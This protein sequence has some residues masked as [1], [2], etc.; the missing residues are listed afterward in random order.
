MVEDVLN[1]AE[2]PIANA[3]GNAIEAIGSCG[4]ELGRTNGVAAIEALDPHVF[5]VMQAEAARAHRA[6][7]ESGALDATL[8]K[9]LRKGLEID[10]ATL[11]AS[12]AARPQLAADFIAQIF[13]DA[14]AIAL[15]MLATRTPTAARM[16]PPFAGF[17][18]EDA[19]STQPLDP[20]RQ[21]ARLSRRRDPGRI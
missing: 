10:D 12:I 3:C 15:P 1:L 2:A 17:K 5:T 13:R 20:L 19:L 14:Q 16:R 6:L 4:I 11:A 7:M 8:T 18:P 9:R 21:H